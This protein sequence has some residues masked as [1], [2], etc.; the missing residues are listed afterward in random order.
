MPEK[1]VGK[2][3]LNL[4]ATA[5]ADADA[6]RQ[7]QRIIGRD[8]WRFRLLAGLTVLLWLAAAAGVFLVLFV[9]TTALFPKQRALVRDG[10]RI[11][12]EQFIEAQASQLE[13]LE[14]CTD[15]VT[16]SSI[17]LAL[18]ALCTVFLIWSSRR[19]TLREVNT[20]LAEISE[21]LR[22]LQHIPA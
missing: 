19:A 12:A 22:R 13:A 9:A 21:Q 20:R 15:V 3:L 17:S 6:G 18:A 14:I 5:A 16:A 10:G 8:R 11:P 4:D 7:A 2:A 1:D